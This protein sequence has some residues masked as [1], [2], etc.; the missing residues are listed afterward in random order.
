[1]LDE[2]EAAQEEKDKGFFEATGDFLADR[3]GGGIGG[4]GN[5]LLDAAVLVHGVVRNWSFGKR[6]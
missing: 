5:A 6:W 1:M 2:L 3:Y 4:A